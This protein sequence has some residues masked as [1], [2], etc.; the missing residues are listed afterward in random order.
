MH[1]I[2]C[3]EYKA[4]IVHVVLT[5][6]LSLSNTT[7]LMLDSLVQEVCITPMLWTPTLSIVL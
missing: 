6:L 4:L 2:Q 7:K 1:R 5:Q 3:I